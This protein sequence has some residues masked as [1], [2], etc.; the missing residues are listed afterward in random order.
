AGRAQGADCQHKRCHYQ[1]GQAL[2]GSSSMKARNARPSAGE[3]WL[4]TST[5]SPC[6]TGASLK[7]SLV[8]TLTPSAGRP[9]AW[10]TV[11]SGMVLIPIASAPQERIIASSARVSYIG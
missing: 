10:Q 7:H 3:T 1:A 6:V 8:I 2:H 9:K 5:T 11:S 4:P